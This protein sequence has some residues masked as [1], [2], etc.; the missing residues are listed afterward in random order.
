MLM[1]QGPDPQEASV[2]HSGGEEEQRDELEGREVVLLV[3]PATREQT[4]KIKQR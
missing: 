2:N 3:A 1:Q 4:I